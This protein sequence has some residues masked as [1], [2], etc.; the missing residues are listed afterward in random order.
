MHEHIGL[1]REETFT[2]NERHSAHHYGNIGVHVVATVALIA[3][4][5]QCAGQLL[6][7]LLTED[8]ASVGTIVH[9]KHKAK[10]D[11]GSHVLVRCAIQSKQQ[12]KYLFSTQIFQDDRL[13]LEG[14]HGRV[15]VS[16]EHFIPSRTSSTT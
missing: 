16:R 14:E 4:V 8:L 5:E 10:A 1:S 9:I 6:A 12:N 3:F 11:I 2:T 15:V 7:N 13:I